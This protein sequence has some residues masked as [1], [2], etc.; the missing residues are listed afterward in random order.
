MPA[1]GE[2]TESSRFRRLVEALLRLWFYAW[3]GFIMIFPAIAVSRWARAHGLSTL[4]IFDER[5]LMVVSV[6][7]ALAV[8][9]APGGQRVQGACIGV[10]GVLMVAAFAT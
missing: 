5:Q 2:L 7:A 9:F 8:S 1:R 6:L 3:G 10:I 4:N